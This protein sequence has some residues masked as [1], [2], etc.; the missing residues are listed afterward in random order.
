M[1]LLSWIAA[2]ALPASIL[3]LAHVPAQA[4]ACGDETAGLY[5]GAPAV[6]EP[7]PGYDVSPQP[8]SGRFAAETVPLAGTV[9]RGRCAATD[10]RV[11]I[12]ARDEGSASWSYRGTTTTASDGTFAYTVRPPFTTTVRARTASAV[13]QP[14]RLAER[15]RVSENF[16]ALGG[17]R[18]RV[19]GSLYPVVEATEVRVQQRVEVDG[20]VTGY[21]TITSAKTDGRGVYSAVISVPCGRYA[22]ASYVNRTA[23]NEPARTALTRLDI[24]VR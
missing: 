12:E 23:R 13:S 17:C 22:I 9:R 24:P 6:S 14:V 4:Q 19:Y 7:P 18:L 5:A 15:S 16:E 20:R 1:A 8:T 11:I 2:V 10:E 3:S 21:A